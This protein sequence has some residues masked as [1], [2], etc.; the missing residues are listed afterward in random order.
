M[1]LAIMAA[2]NRT[3]SFNLLQAGKV[4]ADG[5]GWFRDK[6][7]RRRFGAGF[8]MIGLDGLNVPAP[9]SFWRYP[10]MGFATGSSQV[11]WNVRV[12]IGPTTIRN[13]TICKSS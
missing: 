13:R 3:K 4:P 7:V 6:K 2:R 1:Q 12:S 11:F 9:T 8:K 5:R 10:K